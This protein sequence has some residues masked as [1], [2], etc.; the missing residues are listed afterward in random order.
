MPD[1]SA[2]K[3]PS[4]SESP[5]P[6]VSDDALSREEREKEYNNLKP[7]SAYLDLTPKRKAFIE[8]YLVDL[9]ARQAAIRAGYATAGADAEGIRLLGDVRIRAEIDKRLA[10]RAA[11]V[12]ISQNTI[13]N[14]MAIL[15][16][17]NLSHYEIND[18]GY[19]QLTPD[20]PPDAMRAIQA[21]KRKKIIREDQAGNLTITYEV[22]IKL[23]NKPEPL[24]LLGK[25]VGLNWDRLEITGKD[26]GPIEI[27]AKQLSEMTS[28][29]LQVKAREIAQIAGT[30]ETP[31]EGEVVECPEKEQQD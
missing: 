10:V 19:V 17:S 23:W 5:A 27:A 13:I 16:L 26:G 20:A 1:E 24:K 29:E 7:R 8:E 22:D 21:I 25:H 4:D 9:N 2:L 12:N 14:E 15:A 30:I 28:E 6:A 11:R 3:K 18:Q 31:V